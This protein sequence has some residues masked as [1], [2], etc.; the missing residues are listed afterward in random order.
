MDDFAV[1][2]LLR[3]HRPVGPPAALRALVLSPSR[4]LWPWLTAAAALMTIAAACP[5]AASSL[6]ERAAVTPG[7]DPAVEAAGAL[8]DALGG[9]EAARTWATTQVAFER[10][11]RETEAGA[12]PAPG[13]DQP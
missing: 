9:G 11:L 1:E 2:Q 8:A 12:A 13:G 7:P 5:W 4:R 3:R 10:F 6:V